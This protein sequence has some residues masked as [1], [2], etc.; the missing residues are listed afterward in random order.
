MKLALVTGASSG[1]GASAAIHLAR[2]GYRT[3]LVAR[4]IEK[5][6]RVAAQIGSTAII[7]PCDVACGDAVSRLAARIRET[8][9]IPDVVINGAGAGAWKFIEDTSPAE[10]LGMIQSP[11]L[12]AFNMTHAFMQEM[13][14]RGSGTLIHVGSPAAYF[15]WPSSVGY[16]AARWA[17]R[18]FHEALC[19]D[20]AGTGV[21]SCH[22]VFG[23]T[24]SDY[25]ENNLG[26][27]DVVPKIMDM[28]RTLT[29]DECGQVL[30][31]VASRPKRELMHPAML[32]YSAWSYRFTPW[33]TEWLMR[34]TSPVRRK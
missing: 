28:V 16:T 17:L 7:E 3:I 10:A 11:Y 32:R 20:L 25:F 34:R 9:G 27:E 5:L 24:A 14:S 18:G 31:R 21:Q 29:P 2:Q 13:L 6:S 15:T 22:V 19:Q 23:K 8:V 30:A 1:I 26:V 4:N 33:I 12:G